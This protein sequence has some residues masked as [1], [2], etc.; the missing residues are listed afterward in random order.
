MMVSV[1]KTRNKVKSFL[2]SDIKPRKTD[3]KVQKKT[4]NSSA[5][6]LPE[7]S[8]ETEEPEQLFYQA[9]GELRLNKN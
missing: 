4:L 9:N 3:F 8:S 6:I 5:P 7:L 1:G 2:T